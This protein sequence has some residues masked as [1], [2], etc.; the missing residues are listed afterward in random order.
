VRIEVENPLASTNV[1]TRRLLLHRTYG[2]A[3]ILTRLENVLVIPRAAVLRPAG[4]AIV[5]VDAGGNAYE[6][7]VVTLGRWGDNGYEVIQGLSESD[8]VVTAGNLLIDAQAQI[9]RS[10]QPSTNLVHQHP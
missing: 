2:E 3:E 1:G 9:V 10:G 6:R 7:R 5:Y 4:E 8:H